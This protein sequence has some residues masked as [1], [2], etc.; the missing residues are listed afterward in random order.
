MIAQGD[1]LENA[2][3]GEDHDEEQINIVQNKLL[4][5]TLVIRLHHHGDHVQADQNHDE[6]VKELF[7]DEVEYQALTAV[8]QMSEKS[9]MKERFHSKDP[10][11]RVHV[12]P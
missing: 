4:L 8:L 12:L 2:L 7:G 1:E 9:F 11:K 6:D 5:V 3:P 10:L